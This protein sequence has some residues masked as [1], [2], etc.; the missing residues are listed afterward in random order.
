MFLEPG[1]CG[2][3]QGAVRPFSSA[4]GCPRLH[5]AGSL[6]PRRCQGVDLATLGGRFSLLTILGQKEVAWKEDKIR[7]PSSLRGKA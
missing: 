6:P 7:A 3:S 4:S 2:S 1:F 5:H